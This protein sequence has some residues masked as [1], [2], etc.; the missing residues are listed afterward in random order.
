MKCAQAVAWS[1]LQLSERLH[2]LLSA[3]KN[4]LLMRMST[5]D[6]CAATATASMAPLLLA[7]T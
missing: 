6:T 2:L 7:E 1:P 3:L 5:G 4:E